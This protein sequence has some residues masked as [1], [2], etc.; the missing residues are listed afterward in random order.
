MNIMVKW[1]E[2]ME[3]KWDEIVAGVEFECNFLHTQRHQE[4]AEDRFDSWL[5][6]IADL[7]EEDN[8]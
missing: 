3:R 6:K 2:R 1:Q 4:I 5:D 8:V 7:D